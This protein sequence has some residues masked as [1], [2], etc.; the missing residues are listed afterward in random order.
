MENHI[1]IITGSTQ[2]LG[3]G[4]A[5]YIAKQKPNGLCIC[6][7]NKER[8]L[9]AKQ[10]LEALGC[11]VLFV[12]TDL[13]KPEECQNLIAACDKKFHRIDGLVN[14][15]GLTDR[16]TLD[17]T[18]V[19]LWDKLFATNTRAPF[20]LM[21]AAAKI[22]Q[23]EKTAGSIVNITTTGIYGGTANLIAYCASKAALAT[24][25]KSVASGLKKDHIRVN[26]INLGWTDTPGERAIQIKEGQDEKWLDKV[27][28]QMPFGRLIEPHD[29]AKLAWFL[30]TEQ[31]GVMTG[32][33][34]D[35]EQRPIG[36]FD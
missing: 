12:E 13:A 14:A 24:M 9:A 36:C 4:I 11:E 21:Q 25:T 17:D 6:G 7:R 22:M 3:L 8:G 30:L 31:S 23:R 32:S 26:A 27:A 1:Y 20:L 34:I 35:Y 29:V 18:S 15:A 16:G 28:K 33:L 2:G 10:K 19:E 5:E